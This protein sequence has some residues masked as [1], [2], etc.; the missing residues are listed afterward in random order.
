MKNKGHR[1]RSRTKDHRI[2]LLGPLFE[3]NTVFSECAH[4]YS[5]DYVILM[6][7]TGCA[8]QYWGITL[9]QTCQPVDTY[10]VH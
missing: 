2:S 8:V 3:G 4:A 5:S 6:R 7:S 9:S 1:A 10:L